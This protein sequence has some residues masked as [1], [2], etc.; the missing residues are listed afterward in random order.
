[1]KSSYKILFVIPLLLLV[2]IPAIS[3][4]NY[5]ADIIVDVHEDGKVDITGSSNYPSFPILGSEV[6]TSKTKQFWLIN[7]SVNDS[8]TQYIAKIKLP[9]DASLNYLQAK[10]VLSIREDNG[11]IVVTITGKDQPLQ[12][13]VQYSFEKKDNSLVFF[14][15]IP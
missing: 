10:D 14:L 9:Q 4:Q 5:Y 2:L 11:R 1:M 6:F 8:F 13:V 12:I 3:A 7:I 15:F